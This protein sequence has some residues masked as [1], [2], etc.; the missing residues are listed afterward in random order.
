MLSSFYL[1]E[2]TSALDF[3][4]GRV[5]KQEQVDPI[6]TLYALHSA[7]T[8][9]NLP[10][11]VVD[12]EIGDLMFSRAQ[13]A[14]QWLLLSCQAASRSSSFPLVVLSP[15]QMMLSMRNL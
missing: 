4:A 5:S 10:L 12:C 11:D 6:I 2:D 15:A 7:V 13:L 9:K 8:Q 1:K 14:L 3:P